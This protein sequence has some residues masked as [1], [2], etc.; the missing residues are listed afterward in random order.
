[1]HQHSLIGL[2]EWTDIDTLPPTASH[3]MLRWIRHHAVAAAV[4]Y[5][6]PTGIDPIAKGTMVRHGWEVT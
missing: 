5:I 1:M 4:V 2:E 6:D 3:S